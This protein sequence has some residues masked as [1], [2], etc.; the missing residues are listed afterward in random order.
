MTGTRI[1]NREKERRHEKKKSDLAVSV[2]VERA[3]V[4]EPWQGKRRESGCLCVPPPNEC[5]E[6]ASKCV[7]A[8]R[9]NS[10]ETA[11]DAA[12]RV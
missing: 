9:N 6:T 1:K 11:Y 10:D 7:R 3:G 5:V 8:A 4:V 12:N 2:T